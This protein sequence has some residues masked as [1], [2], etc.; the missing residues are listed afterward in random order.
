MNTAR[1][2]STKHRDSRR[3]RPRPRCQLSIY[4]AIKF[5]EGHTITLGLVFV[6][7]LLDNKLYG[8]ST[9]RCTTS[10]N[11]SRKKW[12]QMLYNFLSNRAATDWSSGVWAYSIFCRLVVQHAA[13]Q[14]VRQ[15]HSRSKVN[16]KTTS[17]QKIENLQQIHVV[18]LVVRPVVHL[19]GNKSK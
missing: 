17:L 3:R 13:Q 12:I 14:V 9:P 5:T 15:M 10:S 2:R 18:Q 19:V 1:C 8:K 7:Y 4:S 6:V 16:S 11:S